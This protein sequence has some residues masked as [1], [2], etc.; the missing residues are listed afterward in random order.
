[1]PFDREKHHRWSIRLRD[2][3][4][5]QEGAYFVTICTYQKEPLFGEI[6][7]DG[8]MV[9]NEFG[10]IAAQC[11]QRIPEHFPGVEIDASVIM[12]NHIHGIIVIVNA[13][14]GA[15]HVLPL[16]ETA[17]PKVAFG[18]PASGSLGIIVGAFKAAVSKRI[19]ILR[20]IPNTPLWQRNY[21]EKIIRNEP[22]LN[23]L[24]QYIETNP[25]QWAFDENNPG[26]GKQ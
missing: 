24:Q 26:R 22:M 7:D 14:V 16:Q 12:P 5:T 25:A 21:H 18:Q 11:W 10:R 13:V 2:C 19:N 1:M 20:G 9:L 17:S 15:R 8:E 6:T 4:Y 23:A 3:D